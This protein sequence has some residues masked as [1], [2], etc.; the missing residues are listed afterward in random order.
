MSLSENKLIHKQLIFVIN[1]IIII[2]YSLILTY[3]INK[4]LPLL[5]K[6]DTIKNNFIFLLNKI[7]KYHLTIKTYN[8]F[9]NNNGI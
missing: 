2:K 5:L 7:I 3:K 1:I 8:L 6:L 9:E 4:I